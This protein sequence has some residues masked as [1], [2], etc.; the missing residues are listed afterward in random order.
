MADD[1]GKDIESRIIALAKR[2]IQS[3]GRASAREAIL[4]TARARSQSPEIL[5]ACSRALLLCGD[6]VSGDFLCWRAAALKNG[7]LVQGRFIPPAG[8]QSKNFEQSQAERL[9]EE[10]RFLPALEAGIEELVLN[11]SSNE[12]ALLEKIVFCLPPGEVEAAYRRI[13][14]A[15]P[16]C[17]DNWYHLAVFRR[18]A[19]NYAGMREAAV[20]FI[21]RFGSNANPMQLYVAALCADRFA[22]AFAFGE[23]ILSLPFGDFVYSRLWNPWG[24]RV[25]RFDKSFYEKRLAALDRTKLPARFRNWGAFLGGV[26]LF[27]KGEGDAALSAFSKVRVEDPARYGWMRFPAGWLS[28][29]RLQFAKAEEYFRFASQSPF[30]RFPA[31]GRLSEVLFCTGR[32][33][34]AL[35]SMKKMRLLSDGTPFHAG[36]LAWEGELHLF[37][38]NYGKAIELERLAAQ[39]HDD[40]AHC[41]LGAA[42]ACSG[43]LDEALTEL[44]IAVRLFPTDMEARTWRAE[45]L[46]RKGDS[47]RAGADLR[48]VL[49]IH[50]QYPWAL[51]NMALLFSAGGDME[52]ASSNLLSARAALGLPTGSVRNPEREANALLSAGKG[53]RR[54]DL[55]FNKTM[56][57]RRASLSRGGRAIVSGKHVP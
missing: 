53:N 38:G 22:D 23:K 31:G 1:N 39:G 8:Q 21:D 40:A 12:A 43:K 49:S 55:Y 10:R 13:I 27:A 44:D 5:A 19:G 50:P 46:R 17:P 41:W 9:F 37:S 34:E 51:V 24:D 28:L 3:G 6:S 48:E 47:S 14:A 52:A 45:V 35:A 33:R 29:Y 16:S 26:I 4:K 25:S 42:L 7:S 57:F 18:R 15:A 32:R 20:M 56:L 30:S 11:P 2:A 36:F 54:D